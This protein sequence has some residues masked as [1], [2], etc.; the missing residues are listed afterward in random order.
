MKMERFELIMHVFPIRGHSFLPCDRDFGSIEMKKRK[1]ETLYI[2][3]QWI[4]IIEGAR[5]KNKFD[6]V[7]VTQDMTFDFQKELAP[8][9][10]KV[11]KTGTAKLRVRDARRFSIRSSS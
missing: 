11:V 10:K 4:A 8:F 2:P 9:F 5:V 6:V 7:R 3:D 1:V